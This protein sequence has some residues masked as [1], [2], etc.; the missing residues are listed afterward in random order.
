[1]NNKYLILV[2]SLILLQSCGS[3]VS[4]R[5]F[6]A[7]STGPVTGPVT[8]PVSNLSPKQIEI[9]A[10][11]MISEDLESLGV[12]SYYEQS[13]NQFPSST[14][15]NLS[16]F[17]NIRCDNSKYDSIVSQYRNFGAILQEVRNLVS[18]LHLEYKDIQREEE[19]S[20]D[21]KVILAKAVEIIFEH[22]KKIT[23][24]G[25]ACRA[26]K[27]IN[28][29]GGTVEPKDPIEKLPPAEKLPPELDPT[30]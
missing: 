18:A 19:L 27:K 7:K 25:I 15:E 9:L 22:Q 30:I 4:D 1:M 6:G 17:G 23:S 11:E 3:G 24:Q 8:D 20:Q 26:V 10:N 2:L 12:Y 21:E 13:R 28:V 14:F 29:G 5:A 16:H